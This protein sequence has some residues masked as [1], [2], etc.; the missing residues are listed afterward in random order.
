MSS[1]LACTSASCSYTSKYGFGVGGGC[2]RTGTPQEGVTLST[3]PAPRIP[4][5][6]PLFYVGVECLCV[7]WGIVQVTDAGGG[8]R[9][10]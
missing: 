8:G 2:V 10:A 1:G 6:L 3:H 4:S 7:V 5:P 9:E